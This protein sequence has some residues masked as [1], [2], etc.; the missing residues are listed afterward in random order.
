MCLIKAL[1]YFIAL[2]VVQVGYLKTGNLSSLCKYTD[3]LKI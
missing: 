1:N 3:T 2:L